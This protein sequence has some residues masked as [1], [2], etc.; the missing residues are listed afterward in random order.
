MTKY[1]KHENTQS[2]KKAQAE[3]RKAI[4]G[5]SKPQPKKEEK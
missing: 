2:P 4:S 3:I 5:E 1:T